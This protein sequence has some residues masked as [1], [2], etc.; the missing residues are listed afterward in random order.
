LYLVL[1]YYSIL[2]SNILVIFNIRRIIRNLAINLIQYREF[3]FK[4][5]INLIKWSSHDPPEKKCEDFDL[6]RNHVIPF[7]MNDTKHTN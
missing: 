2:Q 3:S 4:E 6:I 5:R 1:L 7:A